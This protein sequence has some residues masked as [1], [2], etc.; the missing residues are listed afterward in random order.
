MLDLSEVLS[1]FR[2][3]K[4]VF[5]GSVLLIT[6]L[7]VL[8]VFQ[9]TAVYTAEILVLIDA[10]KSKVVDVEAVLS[11]LPVDD[12]IIQSEVQ[13]LKSR[14]LAQKV[15]DKLELWKDQEFN[16]DLREENGFLSLIDPLQYVPEEWIVAIAGR[17]EAPS[18]GDERDRI[19]AQISAAFL[20]RLEVAPKLRSHVIGLEF[21]SEDLRKAALIANTIGD[22]YVVEQLE[23]KFEAT[24]KATDWLSERLA[25]LR[26]EVK[27]SEGAV[28][29]F[30]AQAQLFRGRDVKLAEQQLLELNT[31]IILAQARRAEIEARADQVRELLNSSSDVATAAQV[32][33]SPL[34]QT[35]RQ[36]EA[37]VLGEEAELSVRYGD[38]HPKIIKVRAELGD[39]ERKIETEVGKIATSL[40]NEV[41]VVKSR[42][43]SLLNSARKLEQ[44]VS[45]ANRAEVKLRALE[46]ESEANRKLYETFLAR[47]KETG[48]QDEIHKADARIISRAEAPDKPSFPK[49][50]LMVAIAFVGSIAVGTGFVF[51]L[52]MLDSG[53]RSMS[54]VE[55]LTGIPGIALVPQLRGLAKLGHRPV[56]YVIDKPLS[57][58]T[59]SVQSV[60][61]SILVSNIEQP[62]K[63]ILIAS[64]LPEEGK[65]TLAIAMARQTARSGKKTILLDCDLRRSMVDQLIQ[66][67][68]TRIKTGLVEYLTGKLPLKEVIVTDPRSELH[69]IPAGALVTNASELLGTEPMRRLVETLA[70]RYDVVIFDSSPVLAI[71]DVRRLVH[72]MDKVVYVVGWETTRRE[73]VLAGIKQLANAGADFVGIV[74]GRVN[75]KKHAQYNYGDSGYYYGK[76]KKYYAG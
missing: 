73:T 45:A 55:R 74:L 16:A 6:L 2:R 65:T 56:D 18:E 54:Q 25:K 23:A 52:E 32:L 3:R 61:T 14:S 4:L 36:Q 47:F 19:R 28:E 40:I 71:S 57:A 67:R 24:K 17:P 8:V 51:M 11:G 44:K 59:E 39:L 69:Y 38:R 27:Q 64:S 13:V 29:E 35:L 62:P 10:R 75:T 53:F 43:R 37:E 34:I 22:F 68:K 15:I 31:Q 9:L 42:E 76:T 20:D 72:F 26:V 33:D 46:R 49:K 63:K 12:A 21:T 70:T 60:W 1:V 50:G 48:G 5:I 41:G 66:G 7:A 30:R 58:F